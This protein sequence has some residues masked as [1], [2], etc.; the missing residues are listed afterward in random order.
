MQKGQRKFQFKVSFNFEG[1]V[2]IT[3][4]DNID[5]AEEMVQKH[6]GMTIETGP[7]T[8]LPEE[9]IEW[10]FPVHPKKNVKFDR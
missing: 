5:Q 6:F 2:T 7:H 1:T 4:A 9:Q 8:S 3:G 10:E